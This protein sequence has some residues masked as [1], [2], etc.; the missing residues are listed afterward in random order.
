LFD[1]A[2]S[3]E[4]PSDD[5]WH[6]WAGGWDV[7]RHLDR[8][9]GRSAKQLAAITGRSQGGTR[10]ILNLLRADGRAVKD[11]AGWRR[12]GPDSATEGLGHGERRHQRHVDD[13]EVLQ[14]RQAQR[15][16]DEEQLREMS[17]EERKEF[18]RRRRLARNVQRLR[19]VGDTSVRG[20]P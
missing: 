2:R 5:A 17:E 8:Y 14:R 9:E 4:Q 13:R 6:R 1:D 20:K 19:A 12:I 15:L 11:K 16:A 10:R 3:L 7:Y 18:L